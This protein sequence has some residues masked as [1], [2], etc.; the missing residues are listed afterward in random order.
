MMISKI[1]TALAATAFVAAPVAAAPV[2]AGN[3][4]VAK[5]A[6]SGSAT[7]KK[8]ELAG[9]GVI[10]AILAVVAIG[11]GI[12]VAVDSDDDASDSN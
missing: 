12:Y 5:A 3:L 7:I 1:L 9:G 11:A 8:N 10:V 6:R 2:P 4:S